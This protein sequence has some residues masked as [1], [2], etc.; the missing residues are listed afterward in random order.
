MDTRGLEATVELLR[1]EV[2][3][4]RRQARASAAVSAAA[5]LL[6]C[7]SLVA[8]APG[9]S[10]ALLW[11]DPPPAKHLMEEQRYVQL[12][13]VAVVVEVCGHHLLGTRHGW[14]PASVFQDAR[15]S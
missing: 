3:A 12:R 11:L 8:A 10:L 4:G 5:V 7:C 13:E 6:A 14:Q 15:W 2:E 9:R 1:N